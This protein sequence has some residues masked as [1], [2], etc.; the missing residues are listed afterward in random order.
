MRRYP[1]ALFDPQHSKKVHGGF[2]KSPPQKSSDFDKYSDDYSDDKYD[3]DEEEDDYEDDTSE[4]QQ[5][6]SSQ[7]KGRH[8][9]EQMSRGGMRGMKQQQCMTDF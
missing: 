3:Y 4:Y 5:K 8:S 7:G 9:K 1:L 2:R 6:D